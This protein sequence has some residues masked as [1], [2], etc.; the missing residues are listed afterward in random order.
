MRGDTPK[1][2]Q[3]P[4]IL[5]SSFDGPGGF[6][7]V[8]ARTTR[9]SELATLISKKVSALVPV[10]AFRE[11]ACHPDSKTSQYVFM[12]G[13]HIAA[14]YRSPTKHRSR[15]YNTVHRLSLSTSAAGKK[16]SPSTALS[17]LIST[18]T[19][20]SEW[21]SAAAL[22]AHSRQVHR[23]C[24]LT[25]QNQRPQALRQDPVALSGVHADPDVLVLEN[26]LVA[27]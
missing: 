3:S 2:H 9:T 1:T 7:S 5:G 15:Y 4:A 17:Q 20:Q 12:H 13:P 8:R 18:L 23:S 27:D 21:H 19:C 16:L 22:A 11:T 24:R 14:R 25:Q 10:P 26:V 6:H